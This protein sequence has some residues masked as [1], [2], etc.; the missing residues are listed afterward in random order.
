M[1]DITTVVQAG[2]RAADD[3]SVMGATVQQFRKELAWLE[4][5]QRH[6]VAR[7]QIARQYIEVGNGAQNARSPG[8]AAP[9]VTNTLATEINNTYQ[10]A[11]RT[12]SVTDQTGNVHGREWRRYRN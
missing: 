2:Q 4:S 10:E 9:S 11:G 7:S 6:T 12:F 3:D 8:S 5:C 1:T